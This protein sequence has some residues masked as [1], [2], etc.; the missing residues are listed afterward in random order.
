MPDEKKLQQLRDQIDTID[1]Q[2]LALLK[3]R[4]DIVAQVAGVKGK[5]PIYIRPGREAKM[6][7]VLLSKDTGRLPKGLIHR[8]WREMIG[9]FTLQE[10]GLKVAVA[11][12]K[13][14]PGLWDLTRDHFGS[15]TPMQAYTSAT[16][17]LREVL[18]GKA[19]VAALS[20][21]K[22]EGE[23]WWRQLLEG[24]NLPK[25][26]Y[27]FPFDAQRGNARPGGD[28][29]VVGN[30]EPEETGQDVTV[31]GVEW[32]SDPPKNAIGRTLRA[33]PLPISAHLVIE[34]KGALPCSWIELKGFAAA[35][36]SGLK[37]WL[38]ANKDII[39]RGR[40]LGSY[41]VPLSV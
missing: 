20:F 37:N 39:L 12:T 2:M 31:L 11:A 22:A 13:E 10:G 1:M 28:G 24:E 29:I 15:F 23:V 27:R 8:L 4:A 21:P 3:Q 32:K 6:M 25:I 16:A 41:P 19:Q 18:S 14:E 17:A 30:L 9:A 35:D 7:R 38:A 36:H 26:F 34:A 33:L 5:L 40:I